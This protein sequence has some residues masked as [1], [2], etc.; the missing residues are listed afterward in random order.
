MNISQKWLFQT[1]ERLFCI[2]CVKYYSLFR[3]KMIENWTYHFLSKLSEIQANV[4][5]VSKFSLCNDLLKFDVWHFFTGMF[6]FEQRSSIRLICS[7]GLLP[8]VQFISKYLWV[9]A[10]RSQPF[11]SS[12]RLFNHVKDFL[13]SFGRNFSHILAQ[14]PLLS[15]FLHARYNRSRPYRPRRICSL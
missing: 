7:I 9:A 11:F 2:F 12:S 3:T 13:R 4:N 1:N 10:R 15:D 14:S 8:R 5:L 6:N